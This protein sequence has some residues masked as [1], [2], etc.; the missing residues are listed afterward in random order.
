MADLTL[1]EMEALFKRGLPI[2]MQTAGLGLVRAT[3]EI[4]ADMLAERAES[5]NL[6]AAIRKRVRDWLVPLGSALEDGDL[7]LIELDRDTVYWLRS[8]LL[9]LIKCAVE[10]AEGG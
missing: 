2:E 8:D 5:A 6:R 1:D 10:E 7:D 4:V 9:K 3:R